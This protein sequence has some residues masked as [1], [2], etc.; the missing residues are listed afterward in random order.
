MADIADILMK[1]LERTDQGKVSWDGAPSDDTF[2]VTLGSVSVSIGTLDPFLDE[3]VLRISNNEGRLL[4]SL[5]TMSAEGRSL[6][7]HLL[8]LYF[9]VRRQALGVDSQL[10]DLL[11]ALEE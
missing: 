10:D 8:D 2:I 7:N 5:D 3:V 11:K 1:L 9:K 6:K 4:E